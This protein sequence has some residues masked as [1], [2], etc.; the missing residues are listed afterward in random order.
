ML[1]FISL[2]IRGYFKGKPVHENVPQL[3]EI[4]PAVQS[5]ATAVAQQPPA[6]V[7]PASLQP[8]P[9][10]PAARQEAQREP[11][12]KKPAPVNKPKAVKTAFLTEGKSLYSLAITNYGKANPTIYDLILRAN[13]G[14]T[15]IRGI[16]GRRKITLPAIT[17]ESFIQETAGGYSIFIGTF[18]SSAQASQ[19]AAQLSNL[20][21]NTLIKAQKFSPRETWYRLTA[22][23]FA[24]PE[25]ALVSINLLI[26]QGLIFI[27]G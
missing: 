26:K 2:S 3:I 24:T 7:E 11:A 19:C 22:G 18:E 21:K 6:T 5:P 10:K 25:E 17:P 23:T 14:I 8:E 16:P 27:P 15:D 9:Q 13:P 20:G 12:P 1:T 4:T